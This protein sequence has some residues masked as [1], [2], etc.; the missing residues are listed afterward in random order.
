[1]SRLDETTKNTLDVLAYIQQLV[2]DV[3]RLMQGQEDAT[4]KDNISSE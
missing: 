2:Q 4:T 3:G 1:M